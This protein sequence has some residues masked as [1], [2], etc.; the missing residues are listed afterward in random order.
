MANLTT[1]SAVVSE[2][3]FHKDRRVL[4]LFLFG[5]VLLAVDFTPAFVKDNA[6]C[7]LLN[8]KVSEQL[9]WSWGKE[10][11]DGHF[12]LGPDTV[13]KAGIEARYAL[14]LYQPLAINRASPSDLVL[15]PGVGAHL[16]EK[17]HAFIGK[18][19]P[20]K[21]LEDLCM[22]NGIGPRKAQQL[23]PLITFSLDE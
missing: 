14:F 11:P 1:D 2:Q 8:P 5:L 21:N 3:G 4:V 16:A 6:R 12:S 22:I 20:V 7:Y 9:A 18:S 15:L 19:G 10:I 23:Q 17:I 13:R